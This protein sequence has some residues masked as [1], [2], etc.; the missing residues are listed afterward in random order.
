MVEESS[1][2]PVD[3]KRKS[4][5]ENSPNPKKSRESQDKIQTGDAKLCVH[6]VGLPEGY[7][8]SQN[9]LDPQLYGTVAKPNYK[10]EM[11]RSFPFELDP[12]QSLAVSCLERHESVLVA[13]HTSA[14][15]TVVAEY[16]TAM[17]FRD[18]QRVLYTSPLKALSNQKFRDF[19]ELFSGSDGP[20]CVG[21]MTGDNT[22]NP[23]ANFIVMTTEILRS[24]L[25]RGSEVLREVVWVIFDE[26]HYMKDRERGV[27]WEETIIL[28][29][30]EV[31]MVFLS[32]T[33]PNA[34]EFA[35]WISSLHSQPCH[36]IG[37]D[38]RP[39]PLQH[40]GYP[41]G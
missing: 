35:D 18:N 41:I 32:A 34:G 39:T 20:D 11:A 40:Y 21:L 19:T 10:G 38:F 24:M 12:F 8:E 30:P 7:E 13:A 17:A 15:K 26:V 4:E 14:G 1:D 9:G 22:I 16:A 33:L 25:Y 37:T 6:E 28:L 27:V 36:V 2:N 23:S 3:L 29:P 31:R 5:E